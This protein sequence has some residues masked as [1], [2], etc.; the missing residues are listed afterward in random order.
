MFSLKIKI[1]LNIKIFLWYLKQGAILT[2]DNLV[3]LAVV[4]VVQMKP[5]NICFLIALWQEWCGIL[6][7][8]PFGFQPPT[9]TSNLFGSWIKRFLVN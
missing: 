2:K 8:L 5:F 9:S 4:F 3:A 7:A 6:L 1:P